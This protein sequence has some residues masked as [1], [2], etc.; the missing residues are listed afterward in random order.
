M[1]VN[2]S[3]SGLPS[4]PHTYVC[5]LCSQVIHFLTPTYPIPKSNLSSLISIGFLCILSPYTNFLF[6]AKATC[7]AASSSLCTICDTV[8]QLF[9]TP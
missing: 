6:F 4:L 1:D 3:K 7:F 2:H 8:R 9:Y 5:A